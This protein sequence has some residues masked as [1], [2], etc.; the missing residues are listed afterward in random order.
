[1]DP[2]LF[3]MVGYLFTV[4][5][6]AP[7]LYFGLSSRYT[8]VQRAFSACW[9]TACTYPIVILVLPGLFRPDQ[10][11]S[12]LLVAETFAAV[13]ECGLFWAIFRP[14]N[15]RDVTVVALANVLSFLVGELSY[16]WQIVPF[17]CGRMDGP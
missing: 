10:R 8:R 11:A 12:F 13:G 4:L 17:I 15:R 3:L 7:I 5:I 16:R 1:M 6:E 2:R 9:L 14:I